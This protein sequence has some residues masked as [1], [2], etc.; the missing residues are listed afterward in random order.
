MNKPNRNFWLMRIKEQF[1][2]TLCHG[3]NKFIFK[4]ETHLILPEQF[5]VTLCH[6]CNKVIFKKE[7]HLSC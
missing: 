3:Y 1:G 7:S 4:K 2:V 5:G 6:G